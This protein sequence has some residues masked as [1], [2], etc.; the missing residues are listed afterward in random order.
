[1]SDQIERTGGYM[2]TFF[3]RD[4][5]RYDDM[6]AFGVWHLAFYLELCRLE[7]WR[8]SGWVGSGRQ[9]RERVADRYG[10]SPRRGAESSIISAL[11]GQGWVSIERVSGL[12]TRFRV[13]R[14]ATPGCQ[15]DTAGWQSD[16]AEVPPQGVNP[17]PQ[18]VS[19]LEFRRKK[20]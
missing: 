5:E 19:L 9:L 17:P 1:M 12:N 11:V 6:A 4:G 15:P 13:V 7:A 16:L 3:G 2:P 8:Y 18:G 20:G 14:S 10:A